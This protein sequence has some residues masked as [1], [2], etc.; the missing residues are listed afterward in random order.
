MNEQV[1]V[2]FNLHKKCF[3]VKDVKSG[4][5]CAHTTAVR[6]SGV[7]FKVSQAGRT[8]VLKERKKNVHAGVQGVVDSLEPVI[9][10]KGFREV[11]YNP[12]KWDSFI[13]KDTQQPI[14][15]AKE[16]YLLGRS[17]YVTQE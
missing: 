15:T 5:V 7:T 2:Y 13:Y 8:R 6:L 11:T 17:I 16:V 1:Y 12:Y 9:L 10:E 14:Y 3:S 4:L